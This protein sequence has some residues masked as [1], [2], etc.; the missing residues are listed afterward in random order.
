MKNLVL[1]VHANA[2]QDLADILR[3][4]PHV[5]GFTFTSVEGHGVQT[6]RNHFLSA[7]DQVVGYVPRVRADVLL[8]ERDVDAVIHAVRQASGIGGQGVYWVIDIDHHGRL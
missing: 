4:L 5:S 2:Q 7:R 1:V 8:P 3:A 6:E